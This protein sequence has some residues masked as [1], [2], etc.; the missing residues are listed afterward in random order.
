VRT[1]EAALEFVGQPGD[2][3]LHFDVEDADQLLA[4]GIDRHAS[5]ADLLAEDRQRMI[6]ERINVGDLRIADHD[7]DEAG[8][9]THILRLADGDRYHGSMGVTADLNDAVLRTSVT[10]RE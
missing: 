2:V 5:G 3:V 7:V 1:G 8:G 4:F 6:G 9:G 10:D